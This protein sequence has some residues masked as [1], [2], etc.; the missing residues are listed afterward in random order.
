MGV[1][2]HRTHGKLSLGFILMQDVDNDDDDEVSG[3][4]GDEG[5]DGGEAWLWLRRNELLHRQTAIAPRAEGSLDSGL[6]F[7]GKQCSCNPIHLPK[8]EMMLCLICLPCVVEGGAGGKQSRSE[9]KS[10]K[11][12]QK[13][14]MKPVSNINRVTIKKSKN[15]CSVPR[16]IHS[17][18]HSL[19]KPALRSLPVRRHRSSTSK[20][21]SHD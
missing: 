6:L 1:C 2:K 14:G 21:D 4:D 8:K 13:L 7:A 20:I 5:E 10:R 18:G 15:V 16:R 11:A 17:P 12:M 9:K 3:D 19:P